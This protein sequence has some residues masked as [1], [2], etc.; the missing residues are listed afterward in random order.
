[1]FAVAGKRRVFCLQHAFADAVAVAHH[2][3]VCHSWNRDVFRGRTLGVHQS[4]AADVGNKV[5][6][7]VKLLIKVSVWIMS[8]STALNV[9]NNSQKI[10]LCVVP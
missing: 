3:S 9:F 8:I 2:G 5:G 10:P 4:K 7:P 1:V 6:N